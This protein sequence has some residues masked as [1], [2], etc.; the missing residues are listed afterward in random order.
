MKGGVTS[1]W[2][3]HIIPSIRGGEWMWQDKYRSGGADDW[4]YCPWC[5]TEKPEEKESK[6][7]WRIIKERYAYI[8]DHHLKQTSLEALK[9]FRENLPNVSMV[10]EYE[11]DNGASQMRR[12]IHSWINKEIENC[13]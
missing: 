7:L 3:S 13:K 11:F 12:D 1:D 9:W 10:G 6:V 2:C 8:S 4:D 5:G